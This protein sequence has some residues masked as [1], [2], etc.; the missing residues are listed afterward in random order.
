MYDMRGEND[1]TTISIY[2]NLSKLDTF[3][4][5][6]IIFSSMVELSRAAFQVCAQ[7]I[8]VDFFSLKDLL[9]S[10]STTRS[11]TRTSNHLFLAPTSFLFPQ[12]FSLFFP[13]SRFEGKISVRPEESNFKAKLWLQLWIDHS[14]VLT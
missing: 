7:Q 6:P 1:P 13:A 11:I 10:I 12:S 14:Q 8:S 2:L 9:P 3:R 4:T 5:T